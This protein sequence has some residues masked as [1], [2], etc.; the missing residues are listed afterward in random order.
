MVVTNGL[1]VVAGGGKREE[2]KS[3]A[4]VMPDE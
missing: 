2:S 4:L 3:I 1:A